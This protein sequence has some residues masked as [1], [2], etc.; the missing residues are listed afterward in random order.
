MEKRQTMPLDESIV[1]QLA[2][3]ACTGDLRLEKNHLHCIAC[4]RAYPII[5]GIPVLIADRAETP[6]LQ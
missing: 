3:P 4:G 2:C 6:P 5:D 1:S